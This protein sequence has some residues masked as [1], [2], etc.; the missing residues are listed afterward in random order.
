MLRCYQIREESTID[1]V[2]WYQTSDE[3]TKDAGLVKI[4]VE[5]TTDTELIPDQ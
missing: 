4:T 5:R 1:T 2:L 3:R